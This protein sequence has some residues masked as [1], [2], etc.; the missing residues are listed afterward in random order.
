M[1]TIIII[2]IYVR[3]NNILINERSRLS[4]CFKGT[5]NHQNTY[6]SSPAPIANDRTLNTFCEDEMFV[7]RMNEQNS[8]VYTSDVN[9]VKI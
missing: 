4:T 9:D 1:K 7:A 8:A 6:L 2:I 5:R 3:I